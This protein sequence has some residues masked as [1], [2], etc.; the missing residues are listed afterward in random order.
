VAKLPPESWDGFSSVFVVLAREDPA[1][2]TARE[3]QWLAA[4]EAELATPAA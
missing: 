1:L 4:I 2:L 3:K